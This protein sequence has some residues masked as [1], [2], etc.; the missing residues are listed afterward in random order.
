MVWLDSWDT[1]QAE[2]EQ[3]YLESPE[4]V[5]LPDP[6]HCPTTSFNLATWLCALQTRY[7]MKYRHVDGKLEL[8][9][10]NDRVVRSLPWCHHLLGS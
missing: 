4:H 5:C 10:T 6:A 9:V 7:V 3:L 2:A 1:F 8:K